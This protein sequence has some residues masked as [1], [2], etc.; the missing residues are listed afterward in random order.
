MIRDVG[1]DG[2]LATLEREADERCAE[3]GRAADRDVEAIRSTTER[4]LR[5][6]REVAIRDLEAE[7]AR[8]SEA[9][10]AAA[11]RAAR[12]ALLRARR[13]LL[14]RV[15]Q[16]VGARLPD[17]VRR[18]EYLASLPA[19]LDLAFACVDPVGAEVACPPGLAD[20]IRDAR[21]GA[22]VRPDPEAQPGF[23][24]RSTHGV[25]VDTTLAS[26]LDARRL[27]LEASLLGPLAVLEEGD[28]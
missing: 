16:R 20:A 6:L 27:E 13:N 5:G 9:D 22:A 8:R 3:A 21:P 12:T 24:I 2:L 4:R 17:A 18:P 25:V 15:F 23:T 11:R 10:L 19:E 26:R 7:L 28:S 14:E 1:I